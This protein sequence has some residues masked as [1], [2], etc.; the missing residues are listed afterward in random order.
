MTLSDRQYPLLQIFLDHAPNW[1]M[2]I[3]EAQTL[4]QTTFRSMLYRKYV[5]YKP[6]WT[7]GAGL[8]K[9]G[10]VIAQEGRD[11]YHRYHEIDR[12]LR[13]DSTAPLTRYFDAGYYGLDLAAPK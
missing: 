8:H 10:F 2:S 11:A 13:H 3:E 12:I 4:N 6:A 5:R 1:L 7:D 9:G